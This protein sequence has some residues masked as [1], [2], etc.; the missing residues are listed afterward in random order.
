MNQ[1]LAFLRVQWRLTRP[2]WLGALIST[3]LAYALPHLI[4]IGLVPAWSDRDAAATHLLTITPI[5]GGLL[6][7]TTLVI[8]VAASASWS[9][10]GSRNRGVYLMCLPM[11]R[12]HLALIEYA[13]A[14][15]LIVA[16]GAAVF[17]IG[18]V[19]A[20]VV[21]LPDGL[22]AYPGSAA[23]RV[24]G[25][26][27]LMTSIFFPLARLSALAQHS[28]ARTTALVFTIL[29]AVIVALV[30]EVLHVISIVKPT[31]E[32]AFGPSGPMHI[33]VGSWMLVDV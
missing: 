20:L 12:W 2:A 5:S 6:L 19:Y 3:A 29:G 11:T 17:A 26:A 21:T 33:L 18:G 13:V 27:L 30:L 4:P 24:T 23:L 1:Y 8:G 15:S 10:E 14:V 9:D 25:S 22:H 28:P 7:V 16:T 31:I 32:W